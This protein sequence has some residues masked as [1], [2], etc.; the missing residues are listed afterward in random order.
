MGGLSVGVNGFTRYKEKRFPPVMNLTRRYYPHVHNLD[1]F[2][3]AKL[4][5]FRGG[6]RAVDEDESEED[7]DEDLGEQ[8]E[9][10][11]KEIDPK[12]KVTEKEANEAKSDSPKKERK[13]QNES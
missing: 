10:A 2:F 4:V 3:V 13:M 1:G 12:E 7:S 11:S 9:E 8:T 6:E 5:K